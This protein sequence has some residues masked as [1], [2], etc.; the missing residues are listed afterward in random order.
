[1]YRMQP[2]TRARLLR[3]SGREIA[4]RRRLTPTPP[5]VLEGRL[6]LSR[7]VWDDQG[8]T[9]RNRFDSDGFQ[10]KYGADAPVARAI[11]AQAINDWS[12]VIADFNYTH[13]GKPGYARSAN[14]IHLSIRAATL[15]GGS[16]GQTRFFGVDRAGTDGVGG[17]HIVRLPKGE[18]FGKPY[19]AGVTLDDNG[20]GRG[21]FFDPDPADS[22]EFPG[23]VSPSHAVGDIGG[24]YDFYSSALRFIGKAVGLESQSLKLEFKIRQTIATGDPSFDPRTGRLN[25][26]YPAFYTD[27]RTGGT[28][29]T[30]TTSEGEGGLYPGPLTPELQRYSDGVVLPPDLMTA[31]PQPN[32]RDR[33]SDV[34]AAL[35]RYYYTLST[36]MTVRNP[37][38]L[39]MSVLTSLN[40]YSGCCA[41]RATRPSPPTRSTSPRTATPSTSPSTDASSSIRR[42]TSARSR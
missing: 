16:V 33:I 21:W 1:M 23:V 5:E 18:I 38:D 10:A 26:V 41:S 31:D 39:G 36:P 27:P 7:I 28:R 32:A 35:L 12:R 34:D 15:G 3:R 6:L 11:V 4:R 2:A 29:T 24:R 8:G 20:G 14:T 9:G 13:V 30:F 17:R 37:T 22:A 40:L 42:R 19:A 25:L